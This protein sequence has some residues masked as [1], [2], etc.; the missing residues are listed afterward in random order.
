MKCLESIH[1]EKIG[2]KEF[3]KNNCLKNFPSEELDWKEFFPT[4]K[5]TIVEN[6]SPTNRKERI[7]N[8]FL[9]KYSFQKEM[10]GES[11]SRCF[12]ISR[13]EHEKGQ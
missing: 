5:I 4:K 7:L 13:R 11:S 10:A 1:Q 6:N 8:C 12:H 3:Y 2:Y 9:G